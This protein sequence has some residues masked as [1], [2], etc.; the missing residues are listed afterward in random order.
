[1]V[2]ANRGYLAE[3]MPWAAGQTLE[4]TLEFIR[5]SRKQ[6]ADNQGL[7]TAIVDDGRI[8]GVLGF[9]RM[10][11]ENRSTSIGYW[12]AES[13]QGRG[14]VTQAVRALADHAFRTWKLT[15]SRFKP[16]L[17][18]SAVEPSPPAWASRRK[19][20]SDRLSVSETVSLTTWCTR[21]L[22]R[23]G[24][25]VRAEVGRRRRT[26]ASRRSVTRRDPRLCFCTR[27]NLRT[28]ARPAPV[29]AARP[30]GSFLGATDPVALPDCRTPGDAATR[31]PVWS[32]AADPEIGCAVDPLIRS[33]IAR[34]SGAGKRRD[35]GGSLS[36][37]IGT[38]ERTVGQQ[39][40]SSSR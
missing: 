5:S 40:R 22:R 38:V 12:I 2:S 24:G 29:A 34:R 35:P 39:V 33:R 28:S 3:W 23:T 4:G 9:H 25:W 10:D 32:F 8:V 36:R 7:Q 11:W 18:T 37:R 20:S 27:T 31:R 17:T 19:A 21:C 30:L 6:L 26:P 15:G 1:M 16:G 14:T 13:S